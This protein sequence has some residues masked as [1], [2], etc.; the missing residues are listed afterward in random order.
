MTLLQALR[1]M[2]HRRKFEGKSIE[3]LNKAVHAVSQAFPD[4]NKATPVTL[5]SVK[6]KIAAALRD[7]NWEGVTVGEIGLL[8][9]AAFGGDEPLDPHLFSFVQRE[10]EATTN[11]VLLSAAAEGYVAGW[12]Q[13]GALTAWLAGIIQQ[14]SEHLSQR[15]QSVFLSIPQA[16]DT[17]KAPEEIAERMVAEPD[18]YRWLAGIGI[19]SP[20][21][22]KLMT[23][24]HKA[25]LRALPEIRTDQQVDQVFRWILPEG[26]ARASDEMAAGAIE[27]LLTPWLHQ[28]PEQQY[29]KALLDRITN[30]YGD[31]R[32][33]R[34]E[35][36]ALVSAPCRGVLVRWLAGASMDALLSVIT[37]STANHMWQPR[38]DFWKGL[39]NRGL[40]NEAWVAL[41]P[42]AIDIAQDMFAKSGKSASALAGRQTAK[43]RKD[44]CL[45][46][47]RVG[48][49][50]VVEG[51]HDYR[52]HV[53]ADSDRRAPKLYQADYDAEALILGI[54]HPDTRIHDPYGYWMKWVE[55]RVVR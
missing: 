17:H 16:L 6:A 51:S 29:R 13:G 44:T 24:L 45:L 32:S 26:R 38:H 50:I 11:P 55:E 18:P 36:W 48:R 47:M 41:S 42:A 37:R 20:H 49:H 21:S 30:A 23:E 8:A 7:W 25:W 54:G 31:L 4:F 5:E 15:W 9:S 22:G 40:V 52:V 34:P 3:R 28:M 43:A 19:G 12:T 53:F 1:A 2:P 39:F 14:R 27:K 46:V 35:F 33:Q 10:V